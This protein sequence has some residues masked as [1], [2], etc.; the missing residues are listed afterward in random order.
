MARLARSVGFLGLL[1]VAWCRI[2]Y[3]L[4]PTQ[5][6]FATDHFDFEWGWTPM[7]TAAPRVLGGLQRRQNQQYP[8]NATCGF[9]GGSESETSIT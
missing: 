3:D 8:P 5:T 1:S 6:S 2:G 7:P 9:V 4:R